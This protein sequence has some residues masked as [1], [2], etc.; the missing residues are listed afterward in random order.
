MS[1]LAG[2]A[3][4]A[5]APISHDARPVK[6]PVPSYPFLASL[7][8]MNGYCEVRFDVDERGYSFNHFTSCTDY[9]FCFQSK[10]AVADVLF[11]P[12]MDNGEPRIRRD[13][14]Y[15]LEYLIEDIEPG[16]VDRTR[17]KPCRKVPIA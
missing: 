12:A 11:E 4:V 8:G 7:F 14:L 3:Q 6:P 2:H 1:V 5:D 17:L 13:V 9:I 15:P 16:F 10:K